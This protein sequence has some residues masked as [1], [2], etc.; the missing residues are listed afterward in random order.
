MKKFVLLALA[1]LAFATVAAEAMAQANTRT[2]STTCS[3]PPGNKTCTRTC[4]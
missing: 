1:V 3:G 4:F 2:C